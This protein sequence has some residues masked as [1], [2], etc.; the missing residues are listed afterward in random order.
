[1]QNLKAS[2]YGKFWPSKLGTLIEISQLFFTFIDIISF[3]KGYTLC[4]SLPKTVKYKK[5]YL[6][7]FFLFAAYFFPLHNFSSTQKIN[8]IC[9]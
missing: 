2:L 3:F 4:A 9:N 6:F 1:M 5:S 8:A 7:G